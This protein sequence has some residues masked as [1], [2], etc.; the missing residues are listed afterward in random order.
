MHKL[1]NTFV[2]PLT[3]QYVQAFSELP[4]FKGDRDRDTIRGRKRIKWLHRLMEEGKFHSPKW[5]T[6]QCGGV[7][8]RMNGGHSSRMLTEL[9]GSFPEGLCAVVD[10][11]HCD[12][13]TDLSDLFL[14]FDSRQSTRSRGDKINAIKS[15]V[16]ELDDVKPLYV[17]RALSGIAFRYRKYGEK[18]AWSEDDVISL[19]N[20]HSDFICWSRKY[21]GVRRL[22]VVGCVAAM[23]ATYEKYP[24]AATIFWGQVLEETH[25][26]NC[27]PTRKL[28]RYFRDKI[29]R[30]ISKGNNGKNVYRADSVRTIHAWNAA[31]NGGATGL[32]YYS[33]S[34]VPDI[35]PPNVEPYASAGDGE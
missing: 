29:G 9:N 19:V 25:P 16:G 3:R 20:E 17:S 5:A 7:K 11:F 34:P 8:Y 30:E 14:Q 10:E 22:G 31:M 33:N 23:F 24:N 26:D 18:P 12:T 27:H 1:L 15:A 32:K 21:A 13:M 28:A 6:A 35:S 4:T 2:V